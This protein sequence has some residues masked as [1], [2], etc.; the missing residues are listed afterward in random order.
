[1]K[2]STSW[3]GQEQYAYTFKP[4]YRSRTCPSKMLPGN[5]VSCR[6]PFFEIPPDMFSGIV[7]GAMEAFDFLK[8]VNAMIIYRP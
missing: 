5:V 1:M 8:V 4:S 3:P 2:S 6:S 7:R